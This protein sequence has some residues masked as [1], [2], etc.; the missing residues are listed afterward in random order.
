MDSRIIIY[1]TDP[2]PLE[3]LRASL[4]LEEDLTE[5]YK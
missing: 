3:A 5:L 2:G 4:E 1:P